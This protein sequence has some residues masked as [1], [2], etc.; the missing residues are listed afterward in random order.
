M[1]E[2]AKQRSV[3]PEDVKP[4]NIDFIYILYMKSK[5][6]IRRP[7]NKSKKFRG[8]LMKGGSTMSELAAELEND[9]EMLFHACRTNNTQTA[10]EIL[11]KFNEL[12]PPFRQFVNVNSRDD[13]LYTPLRY[14]INN[15]NIQIVMALLNSGADVNDLDE[16]NR[17]PLHFALYNHHREIVLALVNRGADIHA[18]DGLERTPLH[19]ASWLGNGELAMVLVD[20]GADVNG[21]DQGEKSPLHIA[22]YGGYR[23][24]VMVLV[25]RGADIEARDN[26]GDT[27]LH[28]ACVRN[29][30]ELAMALVDRGADINAM[31]YFGRPPLD[32]LNMENRNMLESMINRNVGNVMSSMMPRIEER[33]SARRILELPEE[34]GRKVG[35]FLGGKR[36][37]KKRKTRR[38]KTRKH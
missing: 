27:P 25:D 32:Y 11:S 34:V 6:Q 20:R 22:S 35:S 7:R 36:K 19:I 33:D 17:T 29:N 31:N 3:R 13:R 8:K 28:T 38:R 24:V 30:I 4:E 1:V 26:T 16:T 9:L 12:S 5:K 18:R 14:A 10:L 23:D 15:G 37:T 2:N 21:R